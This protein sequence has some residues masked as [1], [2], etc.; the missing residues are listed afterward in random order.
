[1]QFTGK[2]FFTWT[3]PN[4]AASLAASAVQSEQNLYIP[5]VQAQH[6]G[7]YTLTLIDATGTTSSAVRVTVEASEPPK[8]TRKPNSLAPFNVH[9]SQV[10]EIKYV[11]IRS[12]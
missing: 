5:S 7:T 4:N 6:D 9:E 2:P 12:N 11:Q 10:K 3:G 8:V 1:M